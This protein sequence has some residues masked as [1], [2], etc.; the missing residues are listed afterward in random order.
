[1]QHIKPNK[2]TLETKNVQKQILFKGDTLIWK[3]A[4]YVEKI[5]KIKKAILIMKKEGNY[6]KSNLKYSY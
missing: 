3:K 4:Y 6:I 2:Y 5:I 1:M